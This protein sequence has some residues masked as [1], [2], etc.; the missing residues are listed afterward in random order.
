MYR[1]NFHFRLAPSNF[2]V[3]FS[4]HSSGYILELTTSSGAAATSFGVREGL[5]NRRRLSETSRNGASISTSRSSGVRLGK[6]INL[7]IRRINIVIASRLVRRPHGSHFPT[8]LIGRP[9]AGG[10][11]DRKMPSLARGAV[12]K[13]MNVQHRDILSFSLALPT[14]HYSDREYKQIRSCRS[15]GN[16]HYVFIVR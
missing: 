4:F 11:F 7:F 3:L 9:L 16:S 12:Y 14:L 1:F 10:D 5:E 13:L 6:L 8:C 2:L 15:K